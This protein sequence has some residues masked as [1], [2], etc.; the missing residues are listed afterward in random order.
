M[1]RRLVGLD[2]E[3]YE[4]RALVGA[5]GEPICE[6]SEGEIGMRNMKQKSCQL[7]SRPGRVLANLA[8]L[9]CQ[10]Q[11]TSSEVLAGRLA[12]RRVYTPA[13]QQ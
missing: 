4:R 13:V 8:C 12:V 1:V 3:L 7:C 10:G 5:R 6:V 9:D 11:S 2:R